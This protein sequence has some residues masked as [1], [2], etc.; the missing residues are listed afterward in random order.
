MTVAKLATRVVHDRG[1]DWQNY[2]ASNALGFGESRA[3]AEKMML[4]NGG[5]QP[6]TVPN[7]QISGNTIT[8]NLGDGEGRSWGEH[9]FAVRSAYETDTDV[10]SYQAIRGTKFNMV[11]ISEHV[12]CDEAHPNSNQVLSIEG[13]KPVCWWPDGT[14]LTAGVFVSDNN[15]F[16]VKYEPEYTH[17]VT[18]IIG[19]QPGY[20]TW[21][22]FVS[23]TGEAFD[24]TTYSA[25]DG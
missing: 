23:E 7:P 1:H 25:L 5:V 18:I 10:W 3:G 4:K 16:I 21:Y 17:R 9:D 6:Q 2:V 19:G 20:N 13:T 14:H 8:F 15:E 22:D 12:Y 24:A 11:D